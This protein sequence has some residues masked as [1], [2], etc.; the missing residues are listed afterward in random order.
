MQ[1]LSFEFEF[2]EKYL[3]EILLGFLNFLKTNFECW[4]EK[5]KKNHLSLNVIGLTCSRIP[6][7]LFLLQFNILWSMLQISWIENEPI[8]KLWIAGSSIHLFACLFWFS[9]NN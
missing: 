5:K 4:L 2:K 6:L 8:P 7:P 1:N 9:H 3:I